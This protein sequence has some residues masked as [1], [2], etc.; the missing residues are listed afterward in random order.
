MKAIIFDFDGV[1]QN[2]FDSTYTCHKT[3]HVGSSQEEY[4]SYF[5]GNIHHKLKYTTEQYDQFRELE[6]ET[7]KDHKLESK[8]RSEIIMLEKNYDLYIISS[9]SI[10]NLDYYF[11]NNNFEGIFKDVLAVETHK[12]KTEKFNILFQR[13]SLNADSCIFVTDTSGDVL[14]AQSAGVKSIACTFGFHEEYRLKKVE[15]FKIVSEF[16]QIRKVIEEMKK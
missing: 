7:F 15:P 14:E 9:N 11:K 3:V 10:K 8:V 6:F 16:S 4:R 2:T 12:S 13:Y 5:E 1:I